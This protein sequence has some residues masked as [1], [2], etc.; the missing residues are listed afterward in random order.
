MIGHLH[1]R[2]FVSITASLLVATS[3]S[4]VGA[5]GAEGDEMSLDGVELNIWRKHYDQPGSDEIDKA[6]EAQTG[7]SIDV[8]KVP[9][10]ALANLL[11]LW[12]AGERPDVL[13]I[14]G[15]QS[16]IVKLD[17]ANLYPLDGLPAAEQLAPEH[18][19]F[20]TLDGVRYWLP[21]VAPTVNSLLYNKEVFATL[22]VDLPTTFD[23]LLAFCEEVKSTDTIPVVIGEG[24]NFMAWMTLAAMSSDFHLDN[25]DFKARLLTREASF[26]DPEY[27][28]RIQSIIDIKAAGCFRDNAEA[29]DLTG[30]M[31]SFMA[32]EGAIF[33]CGNNC[34]SDLVGASDAASVDAKVGFLPISYTKPVVWTNQDGYGYYLPVTGDPDREA[35]ARA[36]VEFATGPGYEI[37]LATQAVP[38]A[39]LNH[40]P[41]DPASVAV[42]ILESDQAAIDYPVVPGYEPLIACGYGDLKASLSEMYIGEKTALQVAEGM[43]LGFEQSCKDLGYPGF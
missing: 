40:S 32:G 8:K 36:Y 22:G 1:K 21:Q 30:A 18:S 26:T 41:P 31:N 23:E 43:D 19:Q 10:S 38:S 16:S 2:L 7:A 12:S 29:I 15:Y 6:F 17:P 35:A 42:P 20:G 5:L 14:E 27:V 24:S 34:V 13:I 9:A 37:Y 4:G 28:K 39:Y 33:N 11:P 25:P 3:L